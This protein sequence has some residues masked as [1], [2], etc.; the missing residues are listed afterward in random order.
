MWFSVKMFLSAYLV[1]T[2]CDGYVIQPQSPVTV[3]VSSRFTGERERE[4]TQTTEQVSILAMTSHPSCPSSPFLCALAPD[5]RIHVH[6]TGV[7]DDVGRSSRQLWVGCHSVWCHLDLVH[8]A[9]PPK[10][11]PQGNRLRIEQKTK[12]ALFIVHN[13][14]WLKYWKT[15]SQWW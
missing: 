1:L 9:L 6:R 11:G 2:P 13:R 3:V 12:Y 4:R 5:S 8:Q 7:T 14:N 15:S 10:Q